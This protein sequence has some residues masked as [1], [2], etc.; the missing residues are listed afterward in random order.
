MLKS[1]AKFTVTLLVCMSAVS[2]AGQADDLDRLVGD[3]A[4]KKIAAALPARASVL[5][6]V[7]TIS[8]SVRSRSRR[9]RARATRS[10]TSSRRWPLN[11][12]HRSATRAW[13]NLTVMRRARVSRSQASSRGAV[14]RC[15]AA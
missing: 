10:S 8:A 6:S 1:S 13:L 14:A 3:E 11:L 15:R 9:N 2:F 7:H 5:I 12:C 4:L